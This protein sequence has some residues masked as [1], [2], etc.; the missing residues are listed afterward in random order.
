MSKIGNTPIIVPSGVTITVEP[1]QVVI[2]GPKGTLNAPLYRKIAVKIEDGELKVSRTSEEKSVKALHGLVRSVIHNHIV[3][4]T[5][6]Y[7]KTLQLVGTGYR[8]QLRG[9]GLN[10]TV[11]FSHPVDFAAPDEI[12]LSVEGNDTIIVSGIDKHVVGQVAANIR[13]IKP[14]EPYQGKGIRYKDEVVR[15]KQGKAAA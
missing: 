10:L 2:V 15:R 14:P 4:V 11:G 6:G 13:K 9:K 12:K 8:V 7:V 3:G 1:K 5:E